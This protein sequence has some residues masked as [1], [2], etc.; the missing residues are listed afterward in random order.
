MKTQRKSGILLHPTSLPGKFG[1]G[2]FGSEAF[3]FVDYLAD[4]GQTLWQILPLGP[5][6]P[7]DSPYQSFS[8]F[9]LNPLLID[10]HHF[11]TKGLIEENDLDEA[12][13]E[14]TGK[15]DYASLT[16]TRTKIFTIAYKAF[17][18]KAPLQDLKAFDTF[19]NRNN[20]WL[21]DYALFMA[22]KDYFGGIAWHLWP[23]SIRKRQPNSM[24]MF[25]KMLAFDIQYHSFLQ[26]VANCQWMYVKAYANSRNI[27]IIGDIPLYISFDSA[28]AWS[29]PEMFLLDKKL[30]PILVAG[31][32]PDFFS[33]TG[34]LW[35][36]P[37][38]NWDYQKKNGF[39]W[40]IQRMEY[41]LEL[42]D[43]VRIDH[44]RGLAAYWA[45]PFGAANAIEGEWLP[46]PGEALFKALTRKT[47]ALPI[48]AEDLG[49]ITPDV[50][51]LRDQFGLPGMKILQ[52]GFDNAEANPFLPHLF[53]NNSVVYTGTHD[54]DTVMGW[55]TLLNEEDK[56]KFHDYSSCNGMEVHW[57]MIQM[58]FSS[59]SEYAIIP[60]QDIFGLG[61]EARF[62]I[63]G[64]P[65]GNWQWRFKEGELLPE[66]GDRLKLY[67]KLYNR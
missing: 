18:E 65:S 8:A 27:N 66:Y 60:L 26:F 46:A 55:Y 20:F 19:K 41:N 17:V 42:S 3:Q 44:F 7:G 33:E 1:M 5:T 58:A 13:F 64:T 57:K 37:V 15:V 63:P 10:I 51:E 32:P 24:R 12:R 43:I 62:N 38:Y 23:D 39:H 54:N 29:K 30:R 16:D 14:N 25:R 9:A 47:G 34:Q 59:V 61:S 56:Q 53:T 40:W 28:D 21:E 67:C 48:I 22:I 52:F 6:G 31:V 45:V 36:N 4:A 2:S 49:V 35:G 50:D 11:V